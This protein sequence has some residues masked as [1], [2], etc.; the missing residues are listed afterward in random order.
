M[1]F[2][3]PRAGNQQLL[4][5]QHHMLRRSNIAWREACTR[6]H[7][8][9]NTSETLGPL[10][11]TPHLLVDAHH[12]GCRVQAQVAPHVAVHRDPA[13]QQQRRRVQ[14]ARA[15][16]HAVRHEAQPP[17]APAAEVSSSHCGRG[18]A[19]RALSPRAR[20]AGLLQEQL[21]GKDACAWGL[22]MLYLHSQM[23]YT[24][25]CA[26]SSRFCVSVHSAGISNCKY[27]SHLQVYTFPTVSKAIWGP[28][29][30]EA[31]LQTTTVKVCSDAAA[32]VS[33]LNHTGLRQNLDQ[34]LRP[35]LQKHGCSTDA[36]GDTH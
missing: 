13:A 2:C 27:W 33:C 18:D 1:A 7:L 4:L 3:L 28:H 14:R 17:G 36:Q 12:G 35:Q 21:I 26:A 15:G 11:S 30:Q 6:M 16:H 32:T 5:A 24:T 31:A 8:Q 29:R 19:P 22:I 10:T 23:Q 25:V 20:A 9:L 34:S